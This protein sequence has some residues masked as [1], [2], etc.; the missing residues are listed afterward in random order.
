MQ[1]KCIVC[2]HVP[3]SSERYY[4][5]VSW[6][7]SQRGSA[8]GISACVCFKHIAVE[9]NSKLGVTSSVSFVSHDKQ[10]EWEADFY[11]S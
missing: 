2:G 8:Q 10:T 11:K 9:I 3:E 5:I 4:E 6:C 1:L 7:K